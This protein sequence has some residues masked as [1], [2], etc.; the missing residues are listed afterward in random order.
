MPR[1]A[2]NLSFLFTE[3]PFLDRFEAAASA[4][5]R[6]VEFLFPYATP[7]AEIRARLDATGLE[8]ALFN[9]PPG[10]WDK[11]ERGYTAI[12]GRDDDLMHGAHLA[13]TYAAALGCRK[14][15][16]LAGL[17]V[18]GADRR[19]YIANLGRICGI[20]ADEGVTIL[21]EPIN[22]RDMPGYFLTRTAHARDIIAEVGAPNLAL[23]LDL[24]HRAIMEGGCL[25]AIADFAP[26]VAHYQIA[27][28][29]DRGEPDAGALDYRALLAAIDATGYT[30]FVGC[31]YKPRAGTVAG[32]TW[33]EKLGVP[34]G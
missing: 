11:G 8:V 12:P 9:L 25:Q 1:F 22:T 3:L 21:I 32:L 31:E 24:Y 20:A 10:H 4:G 28:P 6:A 29:P 2:A 7:A 16:A 17:V 19:T 15:H 14:L 30:G 23:Q 18:H 33:A 27:S 5:F 13:L 26:I 34:L